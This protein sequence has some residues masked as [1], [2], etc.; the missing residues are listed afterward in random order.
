MAEHWDEILTL[1]TRRAGPVTA[2][3]AT[4]GGVQHGD[5]SFILEDGEHTAFATLTAIMA[6][7]MAR[8]L[9]IA[10]DK[11]EMPMSGAEAV[12]N[13]LKYDKYDPNLSA[14]LSKPSRDRVILTP[15]DAT[16]IAQKVNA[17]GGALNPELDVHALTK[18]YAQSLLDYVSVQ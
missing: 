2:E 7:T 5:I 6:R 9:E 18:I 11:A 3:L 10:A 17:F 8:Y 14:E 4:G 12:T 16:A 13:D 15:Y 1:N